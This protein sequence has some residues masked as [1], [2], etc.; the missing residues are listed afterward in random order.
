MA[1]VTLRKVAVVDTKCAVL[2][3]WVSPVCFVKWMTEGRRHVVHCRGPGHG[4]GGLI[5]VV[6]R[7]T[8]CRISTAGSRGGGEA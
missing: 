6:M 4:G 2:T 3:T 1:R 8:G 7:A 5:R